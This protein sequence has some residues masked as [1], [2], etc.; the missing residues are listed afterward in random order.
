MARRNIDAEIWWDPK[1]SALSPQEKLLLF[2]LL[3][4]PHTD[5]TG[6]YH[7][8]VTSMAEHLHCEE[9]AA[10]EALG[11]L[12]KLG[13]IRYDEAHRAVWVVK[14]LAYQ[15]QSPKLLAAAGPKLCAFA[16]CSWFTDALDAY[17]QLRAGFAEE[18]KR[19]HPGKTVPLSGY[20]DISTHP[21][22][23]PQAPPRQGGD[24]LSAPECPQKT[25]IPKSNSKSV[26]QGQGQ[27]QGQGQKMGQYIHQS[28]SQGQSQGSEEKPT[29]PGREIVGHE[30]NGIPPELKRLSLYAADRHLCAAWR[31]LYPLWI[32]AF[33][34][35]NVR[36]RIK[37]LHDWELQHKHR[38]PKDRIGWIHEKLVEDGLAFS[39]LPGPQLKR[40][41]DKAVAKWKSTT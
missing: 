28:Q 37:R 39:S 21:S 30:G 35:L 24:T 33:P 34:D 16:G 19:R 4:G 41:L 7:V 5:Y 32:D 36:Q 15:A 11:A 2:F 12:E 18:F 17:P 3:T 22:D 6:A 23:T 10:R 13:W 31:E 1:F 29:G 38:R 20:R 40:R 25:P 14:Y 9:D 27:G 8:S 26:H